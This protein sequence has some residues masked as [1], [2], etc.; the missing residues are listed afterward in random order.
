[1]K[2]PDP[3]NK[4]LSKDY[5]PKKK[6]LCVG[7]SPRKDGNSDCVL[8]M[9]GSSIPEKH[10]SKIIKLRNYHFEPCIGCE[11]CRKDKRCS[12]LDDEMQTIYPKIIE[13]QGMILVSPTHHYNIT[14]W[15][16]AFIDRMYCFYDFGNDVPRSWSSRLSGQNRKAAII[17]I[18]EQE[19]KKDM[20]F[21]LEAM[22]W[23]LEAF[24]Y[25]IVDELAV[26]R[27]FEKGGVREN[28]RAVERVSEISDKIVAALNQQ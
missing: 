9:L 22:R 13:S 7:G 20:G 12:G 15:M 26:F 4:S 2:T 1:M 28:I 23:P 19:D 14:A 16:K 11:K 18:C 3:E 17:A 6:I 10:L 24:G 5:S 25:E 8:D 27:I 21:T